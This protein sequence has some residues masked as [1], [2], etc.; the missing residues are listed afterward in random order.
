MLI[1]EDIAAATSETSWSAGDIDL[2]TEVISTNRESHNH[3]NDKIGI[4]SET[5]KPDKKKGTNPTSTRSSAMIRVP[6][7]DSRTARAIC[8]RTWN[9]KG[10]KEIPLPNSRE[11]SRPKR[12]VMLERAV[13]VTGNPLMNVLNST[14]K[15]LKAR[16]N[17][18]PPSRI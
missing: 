4:K 18:F 16:M 15:R 8:R 11:R 6:L 17:N 13:T 7:K 2:V 9:W 1:A 12:K 10:L 3:D 14:A 5:K